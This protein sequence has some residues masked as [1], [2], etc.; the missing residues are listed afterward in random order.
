MSW[1]ETTFHLPC[2][3][4]TI[5]LH[6]ECSGWT[7]FAHTLCHIIS[8]SVGLELVSHSITKVQCSTSQK[9]VIIL[10]HEDCKLKQKYIILCKYFEHWFV[11][12]Q[13]SKT[14][15][16]IGSSSEYSWTSKEEIRCILHENKNMWNE[17]YNFKS[18]LILVV[19]VIIILIVIF[20]A[21]TCHVITFNYVLTH[22]WCIPWVLFYRKWF[23][24]FNCTL[25]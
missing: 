1:M 14:L 2:T 23:E 4:I 19:V 11:Y 21:I 7:I 25:C 13:V 12:S 3:W 5:L 9:V 18:V 8:S 22:F 15:R 24:T 6:V 20:N 16:S 17:V 10:G